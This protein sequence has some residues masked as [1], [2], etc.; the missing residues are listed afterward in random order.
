MLVITTRVRLM[1]DTHQEEGITYLSD[2]PDPLTGTYDTYSYYAEMHDNVNR[3]RDGHYK[4]SNCISIKHTNLT[5][6]F[7]SGTVGS[8]ASYTTVNSPF[9]IVPLDVNQ[10]LPVVPDALWEQYC[11][12]AFNTFSTQI[13]TDV[14]IANFGWELRELGQL[15]PKI[16]NN[17]GSVTK[18]VSDAHLNFAFGWKPF[19]GDLQKLAGIVATVDAKIQHLLD[20][21]GKTTRLSYFRAKVIDDVI[22]TPVLHNSGGHPYAY[23]GLVGH[24]ADFRGSGRLFHKLRDLRTTS[25]TIRAFISAL[26]LNNPVKAFWDAIPYSFVAG[27]FTR[28]GV[29]LSALAIN[30]YKG[31]WE[32]NNVSFSL[33][34]RLVFYAYKNEPLLSPLITEDGALGRIEV[35]RY[36]R[37]DGFPIGV[38]SFN[39]NDLNPSQLTLLGSLIVGAH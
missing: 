9:P 17:L 22:L 35:K 28:I 1:D 14:S 31:Q 23:I 4:P 2:Y 39:L 3:K 34:E 32:V 7:G 25:G 12:D 6:E 33:T 20:T 30:P 13:P 5:N 27:W 38:T 18:S 16:L 15:V 21:Y 10:L 11:L 29:H 8:G 36:T 24:R 26:G 19:V 37:L